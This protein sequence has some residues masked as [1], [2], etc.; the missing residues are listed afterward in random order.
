MR[1]LVCGGRD[2]GDK[3]ALYAKLDA[4]HAARAITCII[5][6]MASG[7]D[8]LA[9]SWA[10]AHSVGYEM[11]RADWK[12]YS[13]NSAGWIRNR[14]MLAEGK[15]DLVVAFPG[16]RGTVDMVERTRKANVE[17]ITVE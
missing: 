16:G 8:S 9:I 13:K 14:Q 11:F 15:P 5:S 7:V 3:A 4:L 6:G 2:Y 17:L 1:V 10:C 12:K